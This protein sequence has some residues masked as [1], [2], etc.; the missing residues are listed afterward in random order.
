MLNLS[1]LIMCCGA[2]ANNPPSST[3]GLTVA[4]QLSDLWKF[5]CYHSPPTPVK[6]YSALHTK[7]SIFDYTDDWWWHF[8]FIYFFCLQ[9]TCCWSCIDSN[10]DRLPESGLGNIWSCFCL[11]LHFLF[12]G[13]S[14]VHLRGGCL[15]QHLGARQSDRVSAGFISH[16]CQEISKLGG[17]IK[18]KAVSE[19]Y[20]NSKHRKTLLWMTLQPWCALTLFIFWET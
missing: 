18:W 14:A 5:F 3:T 16:N 20:F 10:I 11:C 19:I 15:T 8:L 13:V 17:Y 1:L 2:E 6:G 12:C 7:I 4:Q 9:R